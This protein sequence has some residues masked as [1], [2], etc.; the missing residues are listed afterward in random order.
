MSLSS[1]CILVFRPETTCLFPA[2]RAVF[3]GCPY[4]FSPSPKPFVSRFGSE[5]DTDEPLDRFDFR[6]G[7][8]SGKGMWIKPCYNRIS[9]KS[10]EAPRCKMLVD[11]PFMETQ[12]SFVQRSL[13]DDSFVQVVRCYEFPRFLIACP[14][15]SF[16]PSF[17]RVQ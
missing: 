11:Q 4:T 13:I 17:W 15:Y 9:P 14:F 1:P 10:I 6:V 3:S 7:C 2:F 5:I 8:R 16:L 12:Y